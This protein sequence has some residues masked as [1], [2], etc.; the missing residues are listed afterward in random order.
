MDTCSCGECRKRWRGAEKNPKSAF[1]AKSVCEH[2]GAIYIAIDGFNIRLE[3]CGD[4]ATIVAL[5]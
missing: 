2:N 3:W 1:G 5:F 4:E